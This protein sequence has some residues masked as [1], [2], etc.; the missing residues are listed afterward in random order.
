LPSGRRAA[1]APGRSRLGDAGGDRADPRVRARGERCLCRGRAEGK[2]SCIVVLAAG[3]RDPAACQWH[4]VD[5]DHAG[6][7]A[8][9]PRSACAKGLVMQARLQAMCAPSRLRFR[10]LGTSAAPNRRRLM[11]MA[12]VPPACRRFPKPA[13]H[14]RAGDTSSPR[15]AHP[16][17]RIGHVQGVLASMRRRCRPPSA[18]ARWRA[19][20]ACLARRLGTED[21]HHAAPRGNPPTPRPGRAPPSRWESPEVAGIGAP[22][23]HDGTLPNCFSIAV[24]AAVTALSFLSVGP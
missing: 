17:A 6:R 7:V 19:R 5:E 22:E 24:S 16:A 4:L 11:S 18:L 12:P 14:C 2:S 21:F 10:P 9:V 15:C 23:R 8:E 13:H 20:S 1:A 3:I